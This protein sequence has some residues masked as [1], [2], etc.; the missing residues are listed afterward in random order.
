MKR[1]TA[2]KVR[3]KDILNGRYIVNEGWNPNYIEIGNRRFSRVNVLGTVVGYENGLLKIDDG[4]GEI[5]LRSFENESFDFSTGDVVLVIGRPRE[6]NETK[7]I[8]PEIVKKID[9]RWIKVRQLEFKD[10]KEEKIEDVKE[11][12]KENLSNKILE[13]I[14][15]NDKEDGVKTETILELIHSRNCELEIKKLIEEGE[16]FEIRPGILK[17]L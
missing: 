1:E 10:I 3:I 2:F 11:V 17:L 15:S 7:F 14:Q 9:L 13:I 6:F 4:T 12:L 16:I 8:V 5:A